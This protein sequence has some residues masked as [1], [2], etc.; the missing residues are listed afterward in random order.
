MWLLTPSLINRR[1]CGFSSQTW[2]RLKGLRM[3]ALTSVQTALWGRVSHQ[4]LRSYHGRNCSTWETFIPISTEECQCPLES[5][6]LSRLRAIKIVYNCCISRVIY[7]KW[8]TPRCTWYTYLLLTVSQFVWV[9]SFYQEKCIKI[10]EKKQLMNN[11]RDTRRV[12]MSCHLPPHEGWFPEL[13]GISSESRLI[14]KTSVFFK[15]KPGLSSLA[16]ACVFPQSGVPIAMHSLH[17]D[18][19]ETAEGSLLSTLLEMIWTWRVWF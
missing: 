19:I 17:S 13:L 12:W 18:R 6:G 7:G 11:P 14:N 8:E 16:D 15:T 5:S 1:A 9:L 3:S 10:K 4:Q 2:H